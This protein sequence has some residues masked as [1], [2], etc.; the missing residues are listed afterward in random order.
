MT[1]R[2]PGPISRV[3]KRGVLT[4]VTA[5]LASFFHKELCSSRPIRKQDL[6]VIHIYLVLR[7]S[8]KSSS[9]SINTLHLSHRLYLFVISFKSNAAEHIHECVF[10]LLE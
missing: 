7:F 4:L 9:T 8:D 6:T 5:C 2:D 10:Q 3:S 1:S